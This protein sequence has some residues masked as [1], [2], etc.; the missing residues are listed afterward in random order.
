MPTVQFGFCLPIFASPGPNLFR[1]PGFA[2]VDPAA[3]MAM[4]KRADELGYDSLWVADHLMLGKD[5]AILEGWTVISALAGATSRAKLG[6]IHLAVLFRNP[7]LTAKMV[8]TL[9][10]ISG[11]RVI[12]FMDC[13]FSGREYIAYGLPWNDAIDARVEMLT[14]ATELMLQL[15]SSEQPVTFDGTHYAV[16]DALCNPKPIQRPHPPIWFG[17]VNPNTLDACAKYGQGW[18]TTPVSISELRRRLGLLREACDRQNRTFDELE[19][20]LETQLLVAPDLDAIRARLRDLAELAGTVAGERG[21]V[22]GFVSSYAADEDF[23]AFVSGTSDAI[24]ARLAEDWIIGTPD[25]V[26]SR[27]RAYIDEGINH[28]MIWFMDAPNMAGLELF[29]QDV[30]PRFERV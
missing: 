13:G 16:Q 24:P 26:E 18:N 7:A 9:D 27:L 4:G 2:E 12:H 8:A 30:A 6:M 10:Q 22:E 3:C 20:S 28:F 1:T 25:Q 15:W 14:E 5:D 11:G 17:E 21:Q 23:K 19:L 29:A